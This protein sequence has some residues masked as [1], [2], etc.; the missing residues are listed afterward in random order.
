MANQLPIQGVQPQAV[1]EQ[2]LV[3]KLDS[4]PSPPQGRA[5]V[6]KHSTQKEERKRFPAQQLRPR[7]LPP[8]ED[9]NI[10]LCNA[11]YAADDCQ[12]VVNL[13]TEHWEDL[14]LFPAFAAI[15]KL[16]KLIGIKR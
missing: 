1:A 5:G 15:H 8:A 12:V 2:T 4:E 3:S 11:I 10:E 13:C 9:R 6:D 14:N 16:G 7:I